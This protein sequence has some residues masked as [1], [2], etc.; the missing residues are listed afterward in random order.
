MNREHYIKIFSHIRLWLFVV[1]ALSCFKITALAAINSP[2][3]IDLQASS[4]SVV[5]YDDDI[6]NVT[7]PSVDI[8]AAREVILLGY[9][10]KAFYLARHY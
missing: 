4:D 3:S 10:E 1:L 2:L 9:I 6:T 7:T 8:I 5:Y